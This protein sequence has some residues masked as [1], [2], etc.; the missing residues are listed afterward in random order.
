MSATTRPG[1]GD[2]LQ[3]RAFQAH[4]EQAV[5]DD[6]VDRLRRTRWPDQ[7][8]ASDW[9]LGTDLDYL[10]S[11]CRYWAEDFDW[12]AVE[13]R[14]NAW[15][16]ATTVVDGQQV[17]VVHARSP[18]PQAR[19]LLMLHGWPSSPLEFLATL[20]LLTDPVAH[21]GRA[22]DAFHVVA[23]SL[24]GYAWSGP[25]TELGWGPA[26]IARALHAVMGGLGYAQF[27]VF[28]ADMGSPIGTEIARAF[29]AD[30]IGLH[31]TLLVSGLRPRDG[32]PTD[33][34]AQMIAANERR[35]ADESGYVAVQATRPQTLAYA[36]ADSPAGQ[37]AW[38]VEKLRNWTDCDG[39]LESALTRDEILATVATP[40]VTGT[41][42]SSARLYF[43]L[44]HAGAGAAVPARVEVPTGVAV[45]PRELYPTSRRIAADHYDIQH[46]TV[47]PRG[48]HF[49]A[50]EEPGLLV[51]DLRAFFHG[52]TS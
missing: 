50:T 19:P 16:Q 34:E 38:I 12:R 42:G 29:P 11:L 25:T 41:A 8:P 9:S 23:P 47:M 28:G 32:S 2:R 33:E 4:A 5:L 31:L 45:F 13:D 24:P 26:R 22:E 35:R 10:Q 3:F 7:L 40:W 17:H 51:D 27:G 20:P 49:A 21:G 39:E 44:A 6:L 43:E 36:L 46:W 48:G 37:A 52:R 14:L 30:V 1:F 15:P 18:H